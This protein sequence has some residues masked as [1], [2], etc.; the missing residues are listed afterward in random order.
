M[1]RTQ[2]IDQIFCLTKNDFESKALE[3]YRHQA[4]HSSLYQKFIATLKMDTREISSLCDIPFL[5]IRFF[6]SHEITCSS[7]EKYDGDS[8]SI[9]FESSGTTGLVSSKH[10]VID[11]LLYQ[12]SAI[13]SFESFYGRV[14]DTIFLALLPSYL[15]RG[16]SSLVYMLHYFMQRG[17]HPWS[18]F[19]LHNQQELSTYLRDEKHSGQKIILWGVSYA[20]LDFA[21]TY[22]MKLQNT[23]VLE[24]GGM[25]GRRKEMIREELQEQLMKA[26][27]VSSIH[28]EYGMTE[29][30]SQAYSKGNGIFVC[31]PWMNVLVR[32]INDPFQVTMSGK[33]LLNIID[34]ANIHS[35]CFI[36]T[37]DIGEVYADGSFRVTG[38]LDN[39]DLRGC[40]L[41][42]EA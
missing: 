10:F 36:A 38:R 19:Y 32:D 5:P 9:V 17:G 23:I 41:M 25:K 26:F 16:N 42:Y 7:V 28:A 2:N 37:D 30:L 27:E 35:C 1:I 22:P 12:K 31:P 14:E 24:T 39:S 18:R 4:V 6:K 20:L 8:K 33:G 40:S 29:L 21:E 15:E 13:N 34:L 11:T 3:F